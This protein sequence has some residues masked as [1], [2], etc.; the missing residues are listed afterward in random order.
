MNCKETIEELRAAVAAL[1]VGEEVGRFMEGH[2]LQSRRFRFEWRDD[3]LDID[4]DLPWARVLSDEETQAAD[5]AEIGAACR[6][7]IL[8]L[9]ASEA[10]VL[11]HANDG[12]ARLIVSCDD[13]GT[14]Y[15]VLDADGETLD[16]GDDWS[17]LAARLEAAFPADGASPAV[18]VIWP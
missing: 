18:S 13:D 5:I 4:I 12:E 9:T 14:S 11:L 2:G 7:A 10:G 17:V 3:A 15:A 1:D 6:M 8:L 16:E